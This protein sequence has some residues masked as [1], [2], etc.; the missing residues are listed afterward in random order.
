[1]L[2]RST[3][4]TIEKESLVVDFTGLIS[5]AGGLLGLWLGLS[6]LDTFKLFISFCFKEENENEEK[7]L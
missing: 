5:A 6:C 7:L 4:V 3:D 1:M 2:Y